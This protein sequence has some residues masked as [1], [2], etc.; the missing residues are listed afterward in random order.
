[1]VTCNGKAWAEVRGVTKGLTNHR[2]VIFFNR[3]SVNG[4]YKQAITTGHVGKPSAS[5]CPV[6][7]P[8]FL[9]VIEVIFSVFIMPIYTLACNHFKVDEFMIMKTRSIL[10]QILLFV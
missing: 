7:P 4:G 8:V 2:E 6:L 1:M 10:F 9:G 3:G 5:F